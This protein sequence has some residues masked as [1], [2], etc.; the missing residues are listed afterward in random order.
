MLM[1]I[2]LGEKNGLGRIE[3]I[4]KA[5]NHQFSHNLQILEKDLVA[6]FNK[7]LAQEDSGFRNLMLNGLFK[8]RGIPDN[9]TFS[10]LSIDVK[11]PRK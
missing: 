3:G 11:P 9:F 7:I 1:A 6:D 4:Q 8:G 5:Q 2:F 10:L